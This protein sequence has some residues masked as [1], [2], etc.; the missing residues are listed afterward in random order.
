MLCPMSGIKETKK[1]SLLRYI[2]VRILLLR[3]EVITKSLEKY[4]LK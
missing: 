2:R 3:A 1:M 4:L